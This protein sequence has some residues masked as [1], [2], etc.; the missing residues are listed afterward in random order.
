MAEI[1]S[2]SKLASR[3]LKGA[4]SKWILLI[5]A[6]AVMLFILNCFRY[7]F[8]QDDAFISFRYAANFLHGDGLVYNAGEHVEGFTNF[9]WV[10]LLVLFKG[11]LGLDFIFTSR[12]LGLIAGST[13]FLMAGLMLNRKGEK[14]FPVT[15]LSV[16]IALLS[17]QSLPY[18]SISSLETS[19][20]ASLAIASLIAEYH[21][22]RLTPALLILATLLRPE[23]ALVF[24]VIFIH[25]I[26]TTKRVP[27]YFAAIY[28]IPLLPFAA[29]KLLYYGSLLPNP[30][31]AKS[32]IGLEYF[33]SGL[34]YLWF[35]SRTIGVYGI[36]FA[37]PLLG[38]KRLWS[39]F[40]LL[41]LYV[42]FYVAYVV[43]IGGDVLKVYRFFIPIVP[44]LYVLMIATLKEA[45]DALPLRRW[46]ATSLILVSSV[47]YAAGSYILSLDHVA[48]YLYTERGLTEMMSTF[49]K[50]VN[51]N[52]ETNCS[53]AAT[54][55]GA[56]GFGLPGHRV[57]DMLGLTDAFIARHPEKLDGITSS[58]KE[59]RFNN[60]YI[61]EQQPDIIL[62]STNYK[63]SA[64]AER[65]LM[66]H[67]EFRRKYSPI[68]FIL[69]G[70]L[71]VGYKRNGTV[72]ISADVVH[73]DI[74]FVNELSDGYYYLNRKALPI[75]LSHFQKARELLGE[76]YPILTF[77]IGLCNL[78][79]KYEDTALSYFHQ[80]IE[81]DSTCWEAR[82]KITQI[83]E[84][85][86]EH[87]VA[88]LQWQFLKRHFPWLIRQINQ[89]AG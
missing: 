12:L 78:Y 55:I 63:P 86:G 77:N 15:M 14:L 42:F 40:S 58:W 73:S 79:L 20:F 41:Y 80:A 74:A 43:M 38:I 6:V 65:A 10:M 2:S 51:E 87:D 23:G 70:E 8:T 64:P 85:R 81:Q 62:F 52:L 45:F 39:R 24:G 84:R 29:F 57:I 3:D 19:A 7:S 4:S 48:Q 68:G 13:I 83:L 18:W 67:S 1:K 22:P 21:R 44:V 11:V 61:L 5:I 59:R 50:D 31:Y 66:L 76:D 60:R 25:R 49:A 16:V 89:P 71:S 35:F 37:V 32:G 72:D 56:V 69:R 47:G 30:F 82:F 75:A 9:L 28:V 53:L 54:T 33:R 27:I 88:D 34:E 36:L 17:N 46:L 26:L